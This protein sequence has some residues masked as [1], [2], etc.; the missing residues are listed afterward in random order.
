MMC[1][2]V[3]EL[4]QR[5]LDRDLK[6]TEYSRMLG[7]LQQC[8]DCS[9]LFE[10]LVN[11]ST[12]LENL[13]KVTP[14]FSL[15]DAIM[16]SIE[17]YEAASDNGEA[18]WK[19]PAPQETDAPG[20]ARTG[21]SELPKRSRRFGS[22][23]QQVREWVSFPVLGGVVAA[24]LIFGFF[25]FQQD[26]STTGNL[27]ESLTK[28]AEQKSSAEQ[29]GG[30]AGTATGSGQ[31][32]TD[33]KDAT[34]GGSA[35]GPAEGGAQAVETAETGRNGQ[36]EGPNAAGAPAAAPTDKPKATDTNQASPSAPPKQDAVP[37]AGAGVTE[38]GRS[39]ASGLG[40]GQQPATTPASQGSP[41]AGSDGSAGKMQPVQPPPDASASGQA[42]EQPGATNAGDV[43]ARTLQPRER[44]G[45]QGFAIMGIKP[46]PVHQL[47][48]QDGV[49]QALVEQNQIVI[50]DAKGAEAYRS[51]F[52]RWTEADRIELVA[53]NGHK[54]QYQ[55]Q[56]Q[57]RT[58]TFEID[59]QAK[60]VSETEI[61]AN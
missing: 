29:A 32:L 22:W 2:E 31:T 17:R 57:D 25:I 23:R 39:S 46:A 16:P 59:M 58:R 44:S 49:Y 33:A 42:P 15:V 41:D 54:L 52:D 18:V 45:N 5:Y 53:W 37:Q 48:S 35:A 61:K 51:K 7:H 21:A 28:Q 55:V 4:M 36:A 12:E 19:N 26:R 11:L 3:I 20:A 10:R 14:P 8:P 27:A 9:E 47:N 1:Q 60:S 43:E 40:A 6:E 13:P 50:R 24:G 56:I 34:A 38:P 30:S